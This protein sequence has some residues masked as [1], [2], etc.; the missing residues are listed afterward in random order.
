MCQDL[1]IKLTVFF[2]NLVNL[3]YESY[4]KQ[5][6]RRKRNDFFNKNRTLIECVMKK[7]SSNFAFDDGF[8]SLL[9]SE[10]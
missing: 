1:F 4:V 7:P 10:I 3:I 6:D 8:F 5:I 9:T 2:C